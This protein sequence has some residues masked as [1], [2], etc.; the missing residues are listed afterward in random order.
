MI[1]EPT[2][3]EGAFVVRLEPRADE[4]GFFART[5][6]RDEFVAHGID[7]EIAQSNLSHNRVAGTLRGMHYSAAPAHEG[8]LVRC[9]RGRVHDAIVD[10]RPGSASFMRRFEIELDDRRRDALYIPPGVAHGFQTLDDDCDVLYL[11]SER[12]RPELARGVRHDDPRLGLRWPRP[13]AVIAE[14][15]RRWPD[16]ADAVGG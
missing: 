6:C 3:I 11:M 15:D 12:Y 5:W 13:V 16:L 2:P 14:R 1:F 8:K 4:R 10:L 9:E 7:I